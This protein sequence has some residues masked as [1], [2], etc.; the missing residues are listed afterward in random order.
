MYF[1]VC[2]SNIKNLAFC[3]H[4]AFFVTSSLL[5]IKHMKVV[6]KICIRPLV[7]RTVHSDVLRLCLD[8][9]VNLVSRYYKDQQTVI[10]I[11]LLSFVLEIEITLIYITLHHTTIVK[12]WCTNGAVVFFIFYFAHS[13]KVLLKSISYKLIYFIF[14]QTEVHRVVLDLLARSICKLHKGRRP[15]QCMRI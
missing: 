15:G 10:V 13:C 2:D 9:I 7:N 12:V 1:H 6:R 14:L 3:F 8:L 4:A 5:C 11:F